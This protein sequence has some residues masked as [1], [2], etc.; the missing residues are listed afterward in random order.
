[1]SL[2]L[3]YMPLGLLH[4][5]RIPVSIVYAGSAIATT[6]IGTLIPVLSDNGEFATPFGTYP[7]GAGAVGEI[8]PILLLSCRR[9]CAPGPRRQAR[10]PP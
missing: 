9:R 5:A 3:A 7:L 10:P 2:M 6:A 1:M 4:W 8:G